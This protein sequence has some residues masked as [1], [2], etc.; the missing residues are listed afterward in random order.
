MLIDKVYP[1][2]DVSLMHVIVAAILGI[3]FGSSLI[4]TLQSYYSMVINTHLSNSTSLMFFNH[5]Q[6]LKIRFFDEHRVGEIMSRF[7]DMSNSLKAVNNLFQTIF[8]NGIYLLI[9][10]PFLFLLN[11][12]LAVVSLI[13]I[14][15]TVIVISLTGRILRKYWKK[16]A[17]AFAEL[18]AFQIESLS[19][20]RLIKSMVLERYV[21]S[22]IKE[23]IEGAMNI[24]LKAGGLGQVIGLFNGFVRIFN[25]A[26][27]TWLGW[28]YILSKEMTLGDYLAF[29]AYIGYLYGPLSSI[30][31][32]F[33]DFQQTSVSLNRMYEYLDSDVEQNPNLVFEETAQIVNRINGSIEIKDVNFSYNTEKNVLHDINFKIP[34]GSVVAILGPSGSGKTTLLRLLLGM[35]S[36]TEGI[37][38]Y[39][40]RHLSSF[41]LNELR[42]QIAVVW[43]EFSIVKGTIWD[44]LVLGLEEVDQKQVQKV[45]DLCK[46]DEFINSLTNGYQTEVSEWGSSLSGG[47][48][49]RISIARALLRNS[50]ILILDEATSN[51]DITTEAELLENVFDFMKEKTILFVTHRMTCTHLADQICILE[52]GKIVS[53]GTHEEL[54]NKSDS[55]RHMYYASSKNLKDISVKNIKK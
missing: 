53:H 55:Y 42:K 50:P 18:N 13:S 30:V 1:S 24:Q 48:R 21:F 46:L 27:F 23:Q 29:S 25:T 31:G 19:N 2:E 33:S 43:Q 34:S 3:S 10:P 47:Q 54:L 11:W 35:E 14:P 37:I 15:V 39:D 52:A 16:S 41:T 44:N 36:L 4:G 17:E 9:V 20:I 40:G 7:G 5:L 28:T 45:I 49:Q 8:V 12:K 51:I 32:L 26:L 22:K 6:H 38:Q